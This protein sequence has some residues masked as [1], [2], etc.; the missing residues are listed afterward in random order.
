MSSKVQRNFAV[1]VVHCASIAAAVAGS[2]TRPTCTQNEANCHVD[3]A[4]DAMY[5]GKYYMSDMYEHKADRTP[6]QPAVV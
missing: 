4:A 1:V 6:A 2:T 5:S 3:A